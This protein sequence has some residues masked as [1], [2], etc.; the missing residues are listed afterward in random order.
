MAYAPWITQVLFLFWAVALVD[1]LLCLR[2]KEA[3]RTLELAQPPRDVEAQSGLSDK[4]KDAVTPAV[5][6]ISQSSH[7]LPVHTRSTSTIQLKWLRYLKPL[8]IWKLECSQG[9]LNWAGSVHWLFR[10]VLYTT[11]GLI[12]V[13]C[14]YGAAR[15]ELYTVALLNIVGVILFIVGAGGSNKYATAPHAY[16]RDTLRVVLQTDHKEGTVYV[17]PAKGRGFDAVW[18]PKI[19]AEHCKADTAVAAWREKGGFDQPS[20]ADYYPY[21]AA[22]HSSSQLTRE[23]VV[24]LA[25]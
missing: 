21:I 14:S 9:P 22:F 4:E 15:Q 7:Q 16:T 18:S 2:Y 13:F 20:L 24:A 8:G 5:T 23:D 17:L 6:I 10:L 25:S 1:E 3:Q 19:E 12:V 11:M